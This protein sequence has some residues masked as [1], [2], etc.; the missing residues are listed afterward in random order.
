MLFPPWA[1]LS[2]E[3]IGSLRLQLVGLLPLQVAIVR[4]VQSTI[5]PSQK[6]CLVTAHIDSGLSQGDHL[7]FKSRHG[8]LESLGLSTRASLL[9]S[10]QGT[11][12]EASVSPCCTLR[13]Q[14]GLDSDWNFQGIPVVLEK[15]AKTGVAK[16]YEPDAVA[17]NKNLIEGNCAETTEKGLDQ[18]LLRQKK[19]SSFPLVPRYTSSLVWHHVNA[20]SLQDLHRLLH[21]ST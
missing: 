8:A 5:I 15:G 2:W 18:I 21:W 14:H 11:W 4:L 19:S 1:H 6:Q 17:V 16:R 7:F 20:A 13:W 3:L 12:Y 10:Y 9:A